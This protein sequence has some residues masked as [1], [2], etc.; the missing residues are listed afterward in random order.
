MSPETHRLVRK[1]AF[2]GGVAAVAV[3]ANFLAEQ[4]ASSL[5]AHTKLPPG[6]QSFVAFTHKGVS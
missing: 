1:G 5:E 6:L 3:L 4:L 2:W